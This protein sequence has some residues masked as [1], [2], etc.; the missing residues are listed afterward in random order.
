VALE[1]QTPVK[2]V[3]FLDTYD[4]LHYGHIFSLTPGR[5]RVIYLDEIGVEGMTADDVGEL[6]Q[7]VFSVMEKKLRMYQASWITPSIL[8]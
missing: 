7:K 4:R 1:T 5:C 2:P 6:K 8:Q 3:L